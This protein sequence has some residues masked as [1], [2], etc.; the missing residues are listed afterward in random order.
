MSGKTITFIIDE[1]MYV[2]VQ[3]C[4]GDQDTILIRVDGYDGTSERGYDWHCDGYAHRMRL[5][6]VRAEDE[7]EYKVW[8]CSS[9]ALEWLL[10]GL[11]GLVA[12]NIRDGWKLPDGEIDDGTEYVV[13]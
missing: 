10:E 6:M 12:E 1:D 7:S 9:T 8:E 3:A 11:G 5:E 4:K 13:F 2:D